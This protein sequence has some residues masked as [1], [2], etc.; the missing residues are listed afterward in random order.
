MR[1]RYNRASTA[2]NDKQIWCFLRT[3]KFCSPDGVTFELE[4]NLASP[5]KDYQIE[6]VKW[7]FDLHVK[8]V[9][10][11]LADEMGLGKTK[12]VCAFLKGLFNTFSIERVLIIAPAILLHPW[13][14]E[15]ETM[16][17]KSDAEM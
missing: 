2:A 15:L 16:G 8:K 10:G 11:I 9:G 1:V 3:L 13:M 12:Q 7:L 17:L 5:L 4:E 14:E 6:G